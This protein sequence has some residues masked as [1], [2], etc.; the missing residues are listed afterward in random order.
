MRKNLF[1]KRNLVFLLFFPLVLFLSCGGKTTTRTTK[2]EYKFTINGVVVKDL[3]LNKDI[4][5]FT[6]LRDSIAFDSAVVK[7]GA[8]TLNN[9]GNGHYYKQGLQ[10]FNFGQN[11]SI[12]ISVPKDTFSL[13]T[14]ITMPGSFQ[15]TSINYDSITS[16]QANDVVMSFSLSS[17]ASGYF[18]SIVEPNGS[19]GFTGLIPAVEIPNTSIPRDAFYEGQTFVTGIYTVYLVAYRASFLG[20]PGMAFYLPGGLP[21][22]NISGA[23][24]T[25][26]AGVVAPVDSIKAK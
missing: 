23:N 13:G 17:N 14:S 15:I 4:A 6:I 3:S 5:Y 2:P 24:G 10:L 21:T 7:V 8:D 11:V 9:Q 25:I 18:K 20:F 19:N 16:A 22:D 26:G 12:N 1:M